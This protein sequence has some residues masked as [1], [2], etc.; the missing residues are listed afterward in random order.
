MIRPRHISTTM[1]S[2]IALLLMAGAN[3]TP[4]KWVSLY[5]GRDLTGW[6]FEGSGAKPEAWR[7]EG[8]VLSC[9]GHAMCYLATDK[10][11][12]DFELRLEYRASE[13]ANSGVGIRFPRGMWPSTDGMEIQILD[14][15]SPKNKGT[16]PKEL[17]G[18]IYSFVGP[19]PHPEKPAGEWNKMRIRCEGPDIQ[20]WLN[21]VEVIHENLD[22]HD[23]KGKGP[24]PLSK[25]PR[26]GLVGLQCH[27]DPIDFRKI[28]IR[29]ITPE[30]KGR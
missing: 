19:K 10:E 16:K 26:S 15:N 1:L 17:C 2:T 23:E 29:E 13:G 18:A 8:E 24:L 22:Q 3:A 27:Y 20:V 7:A 4:G 14:D 25:R 12:G 28:E 5:N 30:S 9:K 6:H 21:D 11:Y